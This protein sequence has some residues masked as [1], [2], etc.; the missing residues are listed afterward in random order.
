MVQNSG[1]EQLFDL[2]KARIKNGERTFENQMSIALYGD[3]TASGGKAIGGLQALIPDDPTTGT[4]GGIDRS[5]WT[6]WRPVKFG[7]VAD[8]GGAASSVTI[9]T[10]MNQLWLKIVRGTDTPNLIIADNNY[11]RMY[12]EDLQAIQRI[13]DSK[14]AEAGFDALKFKKA[15]VVFDGGYGGGCPANHMYFLNCDYLKF[16]PHTD[17]N[18]APLDVDRYSVNQDAVVKLLAFAGNLT[19]TNG[20]QQGVLIA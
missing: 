5:V 11:Y 6:F 1:K 18:M 3:G 15:D 17:R 4:V 20:R 16:R 7:S 14:M 12:W 2:L 13:Q 9:Q 8:G 19:I 10:Y